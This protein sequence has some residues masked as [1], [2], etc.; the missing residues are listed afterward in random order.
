MKLLKQR[1]I[2]SPYAYVFCT[3]TLVVDRSIS[4]LIS[5]V[6]LILPFNPRFPYFISF[7]LFFSLFLILYHFLLHRL[8][9][10]L[11][12]LYLF[13]SF[14]SLFII[15]P[16]CILSLTSVTIVTCSWRSVS[17]PSPFTISSLYLSFSFSQRSSCFPLILM[18]SFSQFF[19]G[20]H[21]FFF[22]FYVLFLFCLLHISFSVSISLFP[23]LI[24]WPFPSF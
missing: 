20:W 5:L 23:S 13:L 9:I 3:S 12:S 4:L 14:L 19:R 6:F 17:L 10:I 15:Y 22:S 2:P 1:N 18:S 16:F 11:S 21:F 7:S 24:V 8:S